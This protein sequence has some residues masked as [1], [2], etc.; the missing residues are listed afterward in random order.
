[1][2][3]MSSKPVNSKYIL[4]GMVVFYGRHYMAFFYSER[5]D[6]WYLY[7]DANI[8]RVGNWLAVRDRCIRG[9]LQP[10]LIFYESQEIILNFL[11]Q[12]G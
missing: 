5:H 4:R 12:G 6:A 11:T 10:V 2:T 3:S 7:D 9:R 8:H 1:M